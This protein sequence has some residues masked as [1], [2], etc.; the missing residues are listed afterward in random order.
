MF[1]LP[2][3]APNTLREKLSVKKKKWL[4]NALSTSWV[5]SMS[6]QAGGHSDPYLSL[7][8]DWDLPP[9]YSCPDYLV[10]LGLAVA[11]KFQLPRWVACFLHILKDGQGKPRG[12]AGDSKSP[13]CLKWLSPITLHLG[14]WIPLHSSTETLGAL[15]FSGLWIEGQ[16]WN[17]SKGWGWAPLG[18]QK[19]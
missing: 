8:S 11:T 9:K 18:L 19:G 5:R 6:S 16:P 13:K 15:T 2:K 17:S 10:L 14:S 4:S 12:Q 1:N 7:E 3:S